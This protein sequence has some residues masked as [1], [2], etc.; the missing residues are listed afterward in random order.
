M[1]DHFRDYTDV[2]GD[3]PMNLGATTLAFTAY[4]LTGETKYRDWVL[5]YVDAWVERTE[6]N[7]GLLPTSVGLDGKIDSGYGWYGGVYGWGFSVLQIPLRGEVAHRPT[8]FERAVYGFGSA[9]LLTGERRYVD[10]WRRMLDLVNANSKEENGEDA[11]PA[12]V[13]AARPAGATAAGP[14][15]RRP[16]TRRAPRAGTSSGPTSSRRGPPSCTTGRSTARRSTS[17]PRRRPGCGTSTARTSRTRSRRSRRTSKTLRSKVERMRAD[18]RTPDTTMSDDPNPINPATT[19]ALVRLMLGGLPVGRTG[20]PLHCRLR[21]FDPTRR[22][23]GL[24]EQVGALVER[25]TEDE[26]TAAAREPRSGH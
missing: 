2:V 8:T 19:D 15:D 3:N 17:C 5:E 12:H 26:V 21:Y 6:A 10:L 20:Y 22:R 18:V 7:D 23:A 9:L 16:A 24:P 14:R 4:A 1:L 11:V 25:M 13:R